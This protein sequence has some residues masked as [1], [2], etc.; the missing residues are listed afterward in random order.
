[1][2]LHRLTKL[3]VAVPDV[4]ATVPFYRDF[5]LEHLGGG[6]FATTDGGE[7]LELITR[8]RRGLIEIGLG[9]DDTD[10]LDK[11]SSHL[12]RAWIEHRHQP[13]TITALDEGSGIQVRVTIA[14][15]YQQQPTALPVANAPG[16]DRRRN[17]RADGAI[18][19]TPVRPRR[20]GHVVVGSVDVAR[21]EHLFIDVLGFKVSD[22]VRH[23][24]K[25]VRCST[26][27]HNLMV[28][29][30][31]ARFLHHTSWQVDDVD[32]VGRAA[33][34]MVA[35]DPA[36]H[37]WGLGRHNVGGNFFWYLRDPAGN[38]AEYYSDLDIITEQLRWE[39][40]EWTG[41]ESRCA[42]APPAPASFHLPDDVAELMMKGEK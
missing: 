39:P 40:G 22:T 14:P 13:G 29:A 23:V 20:L 35:K 4:A 26:D 41:R 24:G 5:G 25:F 10:D 12:T 42:W 3:T 36:R 2:P 33:A 37:V 8:G 30:A 18:R 19:T 32:E 17:Q 21:S 6:R 15:G 16:S 9:C 31:P 7:Q 34:G 11:L 27:H 38:Y 28:A 1:M